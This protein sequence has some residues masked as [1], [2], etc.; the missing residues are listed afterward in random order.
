MENQIVC[1]NCNAINSSKNLFCQNCGKPLTAARAATPM[2]PPPVQPV[3]PPPPP[4][5]VP[6]EYQKAAKPGFDA[7]ASAEPAGSTAQ[8]VPPPPPGYPPIS[9]PQPFAPVPPPPPPVQTPQQPL[10]GNQPGFAA[11]PSAKAAPAPQPKAGIEIERLGLHLDSYADIIPNGAEKG[12]TAADAFDTLIQ[13]RNYPEVSLKRTEVQTSIGNNPGRTYHLVQGPHRATAAVFF[14]ARGADLLVS[15]DV[16]VK[17]VFKWLYL[18]IMAGA[19]AFISLILSLFGGYPF[20]VFLSIWIS[21]AISWFGLIVVIAA[22]LGLILKGNLLFF[23]VEVAGK[24]GEDDITALTLAVH[25][26]LLKA[27]EEAG[28]DASKMRVKLTFRGGSWLRKI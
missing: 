8:V 22:L 4:P 20:L 26:C 3:V 25:Q 5:P 23:F 2:P 9:Q 19:A 1:A 13:E 7:P 16:Y 24:F 17:V 14:G 21:T 18:A 27:V 15:W 28:L 6:E 11:F 12:S 10:G